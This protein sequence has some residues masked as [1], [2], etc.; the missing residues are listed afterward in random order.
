MKILIGK[1]RNKT[2]Y[3]DLSFDDILRILHNTETSERTLWEL[4]KADDNQWYIDMVPTAVNIT[5]EMLEYLANDKGRDVRANVAQCHETSPE[6][7]DKLADDSTELVRYRVSKNPNTSAE[8]L[9]KL[10]DDSN[11]YTRRNV[12]EHKNTSVETLKKMYTNP[13]DHNIFNVVVTRRLRELGEI[14]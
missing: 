10:A 6:L 8:T 2:N 1:I 4:I 5:D 11:E 3:S 12:A 13:S 9:D 14:E 7:L